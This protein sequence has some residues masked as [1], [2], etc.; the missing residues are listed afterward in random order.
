MTKV[1]YCRV[2]MAVRVKE[3]V[4]LL[5]IQEGGIGTRRDF[6]QGCR[7]GSVAL[8]GLKS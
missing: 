8:R 4:Q 1:W 3:T 5:T 2:T 6:L 7:D